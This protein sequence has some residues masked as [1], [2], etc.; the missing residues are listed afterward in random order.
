[1]R[2]ALL[3]AL[4][5]WY[6]QAE[7]PIG[8]DAITYLDDSTWSWHR[9]DDGFTIPA[10]VPGDVVTDLQ[11]AGAVRRAAAMRLCIIAGSR[12]GPGFRHFERCLMSYD[13][14]AVQRWLCT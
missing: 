10:S 4:L 7:D 12:A 11:A 9:D 3:P 2:W 14:P 6:T 13:L 8:A 1:M 5:C